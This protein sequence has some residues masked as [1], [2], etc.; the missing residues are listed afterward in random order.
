MK[1]DLPVMVAALL[2][3]AAVQEALPGLPC[4]ASPA[5]AAKVPLLPGVA[6]YYIL[7][8]PWQMAL[9]AAL[10]TGILTDALGLLPGGTTVLPLLVAALVGVALRDAKR[11][12]SSVRLFL[13]AAALLAFLFAAQRLRLALAGTVPLRPAALASEAL[14]TLP[15]AALF[16]TLA[17]RALA[18]I[19]LLAENVT[20]EKGGEAA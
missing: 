16:A 9:C 11:D 18:R 1:L 10:W 7:A 4:P 8:R 14:R 2:A 13:E 6:L 15:P 3:A 12:R 5:G 17:V 20:L 19:D